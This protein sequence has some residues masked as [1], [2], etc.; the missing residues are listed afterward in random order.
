MKKAKRDS[1][2]PKPITE[3]DEH[4]NTIRIHFKRDDSLAYWQAISV[5]ARLL[6]EEMQNATCETGSVSAATAAEAICGI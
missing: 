6:V 4:G 5:L 2:L 3:I 1:G